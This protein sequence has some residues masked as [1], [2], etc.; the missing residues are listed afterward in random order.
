V[1]LVLK[2]ILV[3]KDHKA[4]G[5]KPDHKVTVLQALREQL[6]YKAHRVLKALLAL[7]VLRVHKVQLG[8]KV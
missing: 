2:V 7:R 6:D 8:S 1:L 3:H 4:Q 5:V